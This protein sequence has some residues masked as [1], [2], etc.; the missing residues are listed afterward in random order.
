[1][2]GETEEALRA[3]V[4]LP[5]QQWSYLRWVKLESGAWSPAA[6]VFASWPRRAAELTVLDPCMGSGHFLVAVLP[7]LARLRMA[8]EGLSAA[9]AARAVLRDNLHGLE[10]DPRCAQLAGFN[11]ALAAWKFAPELLHETEQLT[12]HLA[13][14]G[15]QLQG[16]EAEWQEIARQT[17][18]QSGLGGSDQLFTDKESLDGAL[19]DRV[20]IGMR[21]L[22]DLFRQAP[23]LGRSPGSAHCCLPVEP[24]IWKA[25]WSLW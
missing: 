16:T 24:D 14:C 18:R 6:G 23:V 21:A 20:V 7:L 15:L 2:T 12:M 22:H 13:C 8:E 1:M 3:A 19:E 9:A 5:G 11:L 17:A 4:A 10:L 25:L